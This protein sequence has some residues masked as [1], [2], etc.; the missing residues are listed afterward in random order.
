MVIHLWS[1]NVQRTT[2]YFSSFNFELYLS[3][4][5]LATTNF[6]QA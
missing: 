4:L 1:G 6:T 2:S 5:I 3:R